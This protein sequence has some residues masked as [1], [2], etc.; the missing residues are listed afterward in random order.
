MGGCQA[1]RYELLPSSLIPQVLRDSV[2]LRKE[3]QTR[4]G[5]G[6]ISMQFRGSVIEM[7]KEGFLGT[8]ITSFKLAPTV[9]IK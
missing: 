7:S 8:E 5:Q 2:P 1:N 6:H 9:S 3:K 4:E